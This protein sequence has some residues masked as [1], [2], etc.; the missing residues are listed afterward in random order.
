MMESAS[1]Y[2]A[3]QAVAPGRLE[4]VRK[5]IRDPGPGE[6]Q[7]IDRTLLQLEILLD[8]QLRADADHDRRDPLI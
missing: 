4:L 6:V 1:T 7:R 5:P 2:Q 8:G 3:V